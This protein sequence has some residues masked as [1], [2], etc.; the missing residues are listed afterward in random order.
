LVR[1]SVVKKLKDVVEFLD[2]L[3]FSHGSHLLVDLYSIL[4]EENGRDVADAE[5]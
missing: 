4:E 3:R 1:H 2:I 5:L